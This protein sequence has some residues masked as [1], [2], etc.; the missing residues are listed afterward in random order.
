[1]QT[2][3]DRFMAKVSPEP[4]T[5]CWLWTAHLSQTG[6][7]RFAHEGKAKEAYRV[8][9]EMFVG[10]VPTGLDLDH[11]CRVRSCVN[12]DHLEPVTRAVNVQ[13]GNARFAGLRMLAKTHCPRGHEYSGDN[14]IQYRGSRYCKSCKHEQHRK[15]RE[16]KKFA[17]TEVSNVHS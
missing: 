17:A 10:E 2:V 15:W 14:L 8:S 4:N 6:Y 12:P 13:R 3:M 9:Y 11:K 1:M 16:G 7:G 5:G